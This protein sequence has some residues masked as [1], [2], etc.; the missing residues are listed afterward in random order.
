MYLRPQHFMGPLF[1]AVTLAIGVGFVSAI[2]A[3]TI[4]KPADPVTGFELEYTSSADLSHR[5]AN[6]DGQLELSCYD[7][8]IQPIWKEIRTDAEFQKLISLIPGK[9]DCSQLV[10]VKRLDLNRDH[11]DEYLIWGKDRFCGATANCAFWI[12]ESG[13]GGTTKLLDSG[14]TRF[15]VQRARSNGFSNIVLRENG[16]SYPDSLLEYRFDGHEYRLMRCQRQDK[17]TLE[18]WEEECEG[19]EP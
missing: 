18:K 1:G 19:W 9:T 11:S 8:N 5:V 16:S 2:A 10:E 17:Q 6:E 12:F 14:G 3:L 15:E 13:R 7:L 4:S